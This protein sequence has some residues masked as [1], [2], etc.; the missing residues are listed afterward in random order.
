MN[1]EFIEQ[2]IRS[3]CSAED[4]TCRISES[5]SHETRFAQNGITQHLAGPKVWIDLSVSFGA[6]SGN[7]LVN[8]GDEAN[9]DRLIKTAEENARLAPEDPEHMPSVG[10]S[11]LPQVQNC[12]DATLALTPEQMVDIVQQT[13]NK[14]KALD[15]KVSGMCEKHISTNG[16]FSKNGF[17]AIDSNTV[18]CHSMTLKKGEVETKVSYEAKDFAGFD[19]DLEFESLASQ[20]EALARQETFEAQKIAVI[21]RPPALQELMWYLS[22]MMNR[23]QSDEG[24]TP[25][26]GMLDKQCFGDKFSLH[27]TLKNP[28]ILAQP[29]NMMGVPTKEMTWVEKGVLKAMPTDRYWAERVGCEAQMPYNMYIPGE[30]ISETEMMKLVPRGLIIN[31]FWYIRP[32]DMKR[33]ELTGMTRDGVLYFEAGE[34]KHAVNNLR[35]NEIPHEMTQRILAFGTAQLASTRAFVPPILVD[36]FNFV[37]KTTF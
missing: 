24:F 7:S 3:H 17:S 29:F 20:A 32:V 15:A 1:R 19:L 8:Q 13:I 10:A 14:A 4:Y 12:S 25:F 18:F 27:T 16:I 2:Y 36:N 26:T 35:F 34:V 33:G 23:R 28:L 9:L 21:L 11:E 6:K 31:R 30:D 37:D 5:D 22:W